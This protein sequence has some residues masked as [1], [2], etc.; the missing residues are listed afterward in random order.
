MNQLKRQFRR[1]L[2]VS[3]ALFVAV[4]SLSPMTY[5]SAA[6]VQT[7]AAAVGGTG[8]NVTEIPG[9]GAAPEDDG[10]SL[11]QDGGQEDSSLHADD[12]DAADPGNVNGT[13]A[14][15][16]D[17][18]NVNG[19]DA[20]AADP[21]NADDTDA[22]AADPADGTDADA[23]DP[24]DA[25][26]TDAANAG[27]AAIDAV[28]AQDAGEPAPA[29]EEI[30]PVNAEAEVRA[31]QDASLDTSWYSQ[32]ASQFTLDSEAK[33]AGFAAIVNGTAKNAE[34]GAIP[35]D[36]FA[37]KT[38]TLAADMDLS[39]YNWTPIGE[40]SK[41]SFNGTFN[42]GGRE[43]RNLT[44]DTGDGTKSG[45]G[46]FGYVAGGAKLKNLIIASGRVGGSK[47]N[48]VGALVGSLSGTAILMNCANRADV[49]GDFYV[50]GLAG[51]CNV[52]CYVLNC[53][54]AG[55]VSAASNGAGGVAGALACKA[56]NVYNTGSIRSEKSYVGGVI[57]YVTVQNASVAISNAYSS[58][59]V[60]GTSSGDKYGGV[61]GISGWK[62]NPSGWQHVPISFK[63]CYYSK[64]GDNIFAAG[65]DTTEREGSFGKT[66]EE[67]KRL[68]Q[69]ELGDGFIPDTGG[70]NNGYPILKW[71]RKGEDGSYQYDPDE[72]DT[73]DISEDGVQ[74]ATA[75]GFTVWM[76]QKITYTKIAA[77]DFAVTVASEG[78]AI[79]VTPSIKLDTTG[80]LPEVT[81]TFM[82]MPAEK[83][84]VYTV[85][86]KGGK[87]R[88]YQFTTGASRSWL[89]YCAADGYA[90]GDGSEE[91]PYR[92]AS[93]EQM[94]YFAGQKDKYDGKYFVLEKDL[95]MS[96][97]YWYAKEFCGNF[98][99]QGHTIKGLKLEK[100]DTDHYTG[101][102]L[103]LFS[104]VGSKKNIC[105]IL[106]LNLEEPEIL[107]DGYS[108]AV[109]ATASQVQIRNCHVLGGQI[110]GL[111]VAGLIGDLEAYG[112]N[113]IARCSSTAKVKGNI[114]AGLIAYIYREGT[115]DFEDCYVGGSVEGGNIGGI[116]AYA[117]SVKNID[118]SHCY[119]TAEING[120][121][122][123]TGGLTATV[124][125]GSTNPI[126]MLRA[127]DCV[128]ES[129]RVVNGSA[130]MFAY[131]SQ[132]VEANKGSF[133]NNYALKSMQLNGAAVQGSLENGEDVVRE[134]L[135]EQDFWTDTVGF[136]VG[137]DGAW[138]WDETAHRPAL[139]R[140]NL[141]KI[142]VG[143]SMQPKD[144]TRYANRPAVFGVKATGGSQRYTYQWQR[145]A[146]A[147]SWSDI[148]GATADSLSVSGTEDYA[149]DGAYFRCVVTDTAGRSG[150]SERARLSVKEEAYSPAQAKEDLI[151]AYEAKKA[152]NYAGEAF[153]LA[154]AGVDLSGYDFTV[155]T[156]Y[157]YIG[158]NSSIAKQ[159]MIAYLY[160]D[161]YARG[162][163]I[164]KY[165]VT[166]AQSGVKDMRESLLK[167]QDKTTGRL[168]LKDQSY[169][170]DGNHAA[171]FI[172]MDIYFQGAGQWGNEEEGTKKGRN[173]AIEYLL[174]GL[175]AQEGGGKAFTSSDKALT[176][177][178]DL[179]AQGD[180]V[181]AMARLLD[182]PD[183]GTR[184]RKA[185][186]DVLQYMKGL[187]VSDTR[188]AARY[189]SAYVGAAAADEGRREEYR[190]LADAMLAQVFASAAA[191]GL[192]T[193]KIG[194]SAVESVPDVD[195]AVL[196]ALSD[197]E[198]GTPA[199]TDYRCELSDEMSVELDLRLLSIENP[200][201]AD[202]ALPASG[203][204]GSAFAWKSSNEN[205]IDPASG[206][207]QRSDRDRAVTLTVTASKGAAHGEKELDLTVKADVDAAMDMVDGVLE[208][209]TL[210]PETYMDLTMPESSSQDVTLT[211]SSSDE[212]VL[213]F[214][215]AG[216]G[217]EKIIGK[218]ARPAVGQ[219]DVKVTVTATASKGEAVKTRTFDV[220]VLAEFDTSDSEGKVRA[221]YYKSRA[222]WLNQRDLSGYWNVFAAYAA[223]G[224]YIQDPANGYTVRLA[225]PMPN[226][227][228]TQYGATVMAIVAMGENPY[229]Y[230]GTDWVALL[231]RNFG[232]MYAAPV[233]S[234]LGMGAAG[235]SRSIYSPSAAS[236]LS[237][238]SPSSMSDGI[239]IAG[240]AAVVAAD[241]KGES[242]VDEGVQAYLAELKKR[243]MDADGNIGGSNNISTGCALLGFVGLM[244]AGYPECDPQYAPWVAGTTGKSIVDAVYDN[245]FSDAGETIQ[246]YGDQAEMNMC[247]Y[248]NAKYNNRANSWIVCRVSKER[249]EA[250]I[251]KA[252]ALLT[253][254]DAYMKESV[255]AV[256]QS[257]AAARAISKER[258]EAKIADYGKEYYDLFDAVRY[259]RKA[260]S[261][262]IVNAET[263]IRAIGEVA[264][265][266][267][268]KEKIAAA[269]KAYDE[270]TE[271]QRERIPSGTLA[272]LIKAEEDYAA[273]KKA[274][275]DKAEA[276]KADQSAA[277]AVTEQIEA[278]GNVTLH[279]AS[280]I[281]K[282]REAY[283]ALTAAQ[284]ELVS[285]AVR[286]K[287]A[288]AEEKLAGLQK[289][290]SEAIVNAETLIRAIG[291]V[292]YTDSVKEKIAAARKAYDELTEAQRERIPSGTLAIL[293]KAEEDYA[294]LK[295]AADDKAEADKADQSAAQAVTKQIEA[296]GDVTLHK[297]SQISKARKAYD[298]L[299]AAQ[300][301]LVSEAARNK[302]AQ[303]E[304]KLADLQEKENKKK[305]QWQSKK[306]A[307]VTE[308]AAKGSKVNTKKDGTAALS[309]I[310][311]TKAK[312]VTVPSAVKIGKKSYKVTAVEADA[313]KKATKAESI[314][315]PKTVKTV[316][317]NAFRKNA[318]LKTVNIK[319]AGQKITLQ[320]N[321]FAGAKNLRRINIQIT[322]ASSLIVKKG[323]FKGLNTRKMTI[324]V[325]KKTKA[326]ELVKIRKRL[327][328]AGFKGKVTK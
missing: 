318:K 268:V 27:N 226:W 175:K 116:F 281:S 229:N 62:Q 296:I 313:F 236:A 276:D 251:A 156:Y 231:K 98:D 34:G 192:Y 18:D 203:R 136:G 89:G 140:E 84:T 182:D 220:T 8:E 121:G 194:K 96:G 100:G 169:K 79:E 146:D 278:I 327:K 131:A 309:A 211:W 91:N 49:T 6:S 31:A 45:V 102:R 225:E 130:R 261:E 204:F 114:A 187:N 218:I 40:T 93:E 47:C 23:A 234:E 109:A 244:N 270:L 65:G 247:D 178:A 3:M 32:E 170:V 43:I 141:A 33:L 51:S 258:L 298:A 207:V 206:A 42:G 103:G 12:A 180:Y 37:G 198:K 205:V 172:A 223:L 150:E 286:N 248:Y 2:G 152:L 212:K 319:N 154:N 147:D 307:S 64:T 324:R 145:L 216:D 166:G 74:N 262:A 287:L 77:D 125:R 44:I 308:G 215:P 30:E 314:T 241:H 157:G 265:T 295:K 101:T 197:Y 48:T 70:E 88:R 303:A 99:G 233:Y 246:G 158:E 326:K 159:N 224:D 66:Q 135:S 57:G 256:E 193:E 219:D 1:W 164:T 71:Q 325:N 239:D 210:A 87:E 10:L 161:A 38:V 273:L 119:V 290:E 24:G 190:A 189:V 320:K 195:V 264:Y 54:N 124:L 41:K 19:T 108:G 29:L 275:D 201:L 199:F 105:Y 213:S 68:T 4:T 292:A 139:S 155:P 181:L 240:W 285:E 35:Q 252:E 272:I 153:A 16:V 11:A 61:G 149:V 221:A 113:S 126:G 123:V 245:T 111:H 112:T 21:G 143:I 26:D 238:M 250:Q 200:V 117:F 294:A 107:N 209:L 104:A 185:M 75:T 299:T 129:P 5:A 208:K 165:P 235:A 110:E 171:L 162:T 255:D 183:Y 9:E 28:P 14:D 138:S 249:L 118:I 173:G 82:E 39:A 177:E 95:D 142:G 46:L 92:I 122:G 127:S 78:K 160:L 128:C 214:V 52:N 228:G 132:L 280:E 191:D 282:A 94:A 310:K 254:K 56:D 283:E 227:Y 188:T 291:E 293:I 60:T 179:T 22:D 36:N 311:S 83:A 306:G 15:A 305:N 69:E 81:F 322:K 257:L 86:Y 115:I 316:K 186:D 328:A 242:G 222:H 55:S 20:D 260:D 58:G 202:V 151:A 133:S 289:E 148:E 176:A 73:L 263:L 279:K 90:G 167:D 67:L 297:A 312:K 269:R 321:A 284:K 120:T 63:N 163:D 266:D 237:L 106:N 317:A 274:A 288:Q 196:L 230:K 315:L 17:P 184:A 174:S 302:L 59:T 243:G 168:D 80:E 259:A 300:K 144:A 53:C 7:E 301:K 217:G 25:D 253:D 304:E 97:H 76:N 323:A 267:S 72:A 13:D 50:G 232:G 271:A 85:R 137:G 134:R 277:Q